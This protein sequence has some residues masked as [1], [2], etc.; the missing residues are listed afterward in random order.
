[1][2]LQRPKNLYQYLSNK[3]IVYKLPK[4]MKEKKLNLYKKVTNS[5]ISL[6]L[7]ENSN[8][9]PFILPNIGSITKRDGIFER[10]SSFKKMQILKK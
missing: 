2:I 10:K 9:V 6:N 8:F 1:M 5:V 7:I 3:K 4:I